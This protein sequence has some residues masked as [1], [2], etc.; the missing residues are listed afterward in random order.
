MSIAALAAL[1]A[2]SAVG[3][4]GCGGPTSVAAGTGGSP[5]PS[6][7]EDPAGGSCAAVVVEV[8]DVTDL[9]WT[10]VNGFPQATDADLRKPGGRQCHFEVAATDTYPAAMMTMTFYRVDRQFHT[11]EDVLERAREDARCTENLPSPPAGTVLAVQ[12]MQ[13]VPKVFNVLTAL[14]VPRGYVEVWVGTNTATGTPEQHA[15]ARD[16]GRRA[17]VVALGLL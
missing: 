9:T 7:S 3:A 14:S 13:T 4:A 6:P 15:R 2:L 11:P 16:I 12:C 8:N 10:F 1:V 17:A 5:S